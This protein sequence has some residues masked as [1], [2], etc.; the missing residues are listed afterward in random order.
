MS[1]QDID[2][3][4]LFEIEEVAESIQTGE[5]VEVEFRRNWTPDV[6]AYEML[7]GRLWSVATWYDYDLIDGFERYCG[8]WFNA[9]GKTSDGRP[10]AV[11]VVLR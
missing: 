2:D 1:T 8:R 4:M 9:S 10:W 6:D 5:V 3:D 11:E 7:T